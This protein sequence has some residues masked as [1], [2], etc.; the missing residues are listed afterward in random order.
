MGEPKENTIHVIQGH[1]VVSDRPGDVLTTVLGSCIAACLFD[2]VARIGGMN[3]FLLPGRDPETR[4]NVKYGAHSMEQLI[5]GMLRA[6]AQR[7]RIEA[8]LFGGGNV[9]KGL[10]RIGDSNR[11]FA[12]D[13]VRQEGFALRTNDTGGTSG[14][15]LRFWPNTGKSH[16]RRL[17]QGVADLWK[18]EAAPRPRLQPGGDVELF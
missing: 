3:H 8:H 5:N 7:H 15:R 16:V 11:D 18:I 9:V 2:P 6:G 13:F 12:V 10:F 4:S 17:D 1:F 14:R